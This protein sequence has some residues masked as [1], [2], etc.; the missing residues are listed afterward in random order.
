[1]IFIKYILA[2][3]VLP[4]IGGL[5]TGVDRKLTARLQGRYGPPILQPFYD[6]LK[7]VGKQRQLVNG[8]QAL[9][10]CIYFTSSA[11]S[12]LL[13]VLKQDLLMIVFVMSIG[14][15]F[16]VIGALSVKS[17]YSQVGSQRELLQMLAYEPLL[18]LVI[19][20][21]YLVTGSFNISVISS[22]PLPLIVKLPLIFLVMSIVLGIKLRKSPFDISASEHAHQEIVRGVLTDY[23]GLYLALVE[24]A[25]WYDLMLLLGIIML[26]FANNWILGAAVALAYVLFEIFIDNVTARLTIRWMIQFTWIVGLI[27]AV[28]NITWLY[29]VK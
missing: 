25:H 7:L 3:V 17:P 27:L 21:M 16:L 26:F 8:F 11:L 28:A 24:A 13:F 29:F 15:V 10:A 2:L 4:I 19:V 18:I 12:L 23:S 6:F 1:M 9:S 22:Y 20:G 5:I 14:A